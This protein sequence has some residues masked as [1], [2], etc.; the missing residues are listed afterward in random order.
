MTSVNYV[1]CWRYSDN[2]AFGIVGYSFDK[3]NADAILAMLKEHSDTKQFWII[4]TPALP[5]HQ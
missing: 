3:A 4:E 1:V 5:V 2:S